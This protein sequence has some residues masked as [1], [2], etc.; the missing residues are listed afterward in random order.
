MFMTGQ[1]N[2]DFVVEP[3]EDLSKSS[4]DLFSPKSLGLVVLSLRSIVNMISDDEFAP[5]F[6][7]GK[8][9]F[10]PLQ[11]P[12]LLALLKSLIIFNAESNSIHSENGNIAPRNVHSVV[13]TIHES[14]GHEVSVDVLRV[15]GMIVEPTL[16][17][18]RVEVP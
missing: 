9:L 14:C 5:T 10:K 13:A 18:L 15:E 8:L 6:S 16:H 7:S 3:F 12:V 1:F 4:S 2:D 17:D 11:L